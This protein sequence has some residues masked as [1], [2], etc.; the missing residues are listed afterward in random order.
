MTGDLLEYSPGQRVDVEPVADADGNMPTRGDGVEIVGENRS[1]TQVQVTQGPDSYGIGHL[2][3][4]PEEHEEGDTY[5]AGETAGE[6]TVFLY[7]PVVLLNPDD[8]YTPTAGD[9]VGWD[10]GGV[11][12]A[13]AGVTATSVGTLTNDLGHDADG[14]LETLAGTD[15]DI[16]LGQGPIGVVFAT[17]TKDFGSAGKVA[18]AKFD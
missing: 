8:A 14:N 15:T 12:S 5:A 10:A 18:V 9:L 4:D 13:D 1:Y 3:V 7:H 16:A 17:G 11:V 6:S 2:T